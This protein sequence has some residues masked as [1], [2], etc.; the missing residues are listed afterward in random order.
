MKLRFLQKDINNADWFGLLTKYDAPEVDLFCLGELAT[1]GCLYQLRPFESLDNIIEKLA[2][3]RSPLMLGLPRETESG[4]RN[5]FLYYENGRMQFYNKRNL[6]P[7]M[8]EDNVY[9]PGE[10]P[11]IFDTVAGR[12]GVAICY[13]LRFAEVFDDLKAGGAE[14]IFVPAA[15]PRVRVDDWRR[16][17]A[18]RAEQTGLPVIGINTVGDDGTN[19]FGGSTMMVQP[20]G[21]I[22]AQLDETSETYLDIELEREAFASGN[23]QIRTE[24]EQGPS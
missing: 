8:N 21:E 7:P 22:V 5:S 24:H 9:M 1:S 12:I 2:Q 11:G 13:D 14:M 4:R 3:F 23:L 17:L 18:E 10:K 6:F 15:F 16:L 20:N 19:E